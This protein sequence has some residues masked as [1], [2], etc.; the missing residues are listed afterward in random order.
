MSDTTLPPITATTLRNHIDGAWHEAEAAEALTDRDPATGEVLAQVPLSGATAVGA[1]AAA[2]KSAQREWREVP[3]QVRARHL[4]RLR[5]VLDAHRD[6]LAALVTR[7]MGKTLPDA[8]GEV[9]RGIESV[10]AAIGIPHLL[11]GENLEGVARGVDVEMVRQPVGVVGAITPFNFPAMIPLWFLPFAV[12][13]GNTFV[14]KPSEQDPLPAVRIF[15]LIAEHEVFPPGVVNL[16]HGGHDAV[17]AL[18]DSDDVDAI[19]FVGSAR[20]ARYVASRA[21]ERGKR[22]QALGGAKNAMVAMPDADPEVLA[23]G[24]TSSA[25]GAAGQRCLAGS[26]L[27]LVGEREEQDRTLATVLEASRALVVGAGG[28]EATDVCPLVSDSARDRVVGEIDRAVAEGA[29]AVLD[30]REVESGPGGA[31]LGPTILD[32]VPPDAPAAKEELFGPVLTVLRAPDLDT[33]I[34]AVNTSRYGN[35]SVLFT[36]SGG[37]ARA[38]RRGVEAGMVGVNIG[39]AAPIAWFPFS[40]WKD[41]IDGD[42]HANGTD[43]V[44][45]YTRKKVV[46]SRW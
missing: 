8:A 32:R 18:L 36:T 40:G 44:D 11:K 14:L 38:Y 15:E 10:E 27:V 41:S 43:A 37:A 16:V 28:E 33:A 31:A 9:G 34:T 3:P 20:T 39:V 46:T 4:M 26:L 29:E 30:G 17:N 6:E 22:A 19:S 45:F 21:A 1:A 42:L 7:D 13:C 2:A 35:S 24:V 12:A 25:F 5:S 23:A